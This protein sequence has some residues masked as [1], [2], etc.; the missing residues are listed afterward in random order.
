MTSY[1]LQPIYLSGY[2]HGSAFHQDLKS[3]SIAAVINNVSEVLQAIDGTSTYLHRAYKTTWSLSW[4]IIVFSGSEA[5]PLA[6][7]SKLRHLYQGFSSTNTSI[8]L[9]YEGKEY[10]VFFE[11]NSWQAEL[12]ATNVSMTKKPYYNVSFRLVEI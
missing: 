3:T 2:L 10:S 8:V 5:Y 12:A 4:N 1:T 7:V 6:T 9:G 11:P